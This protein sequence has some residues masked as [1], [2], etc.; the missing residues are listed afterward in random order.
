MHHLQLPAAM[1]P[2]A[3]AQAQAPVVVQGSGSSTVAAETPSQRA[4]DGTDA[5]QEV[6]PERALGEESSALASKQGKLTRS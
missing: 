3:P 4:G 1:Q 2:H 5:H 6:N